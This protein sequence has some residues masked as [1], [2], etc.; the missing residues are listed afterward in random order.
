MIKKGEVIRYDGYLNYLVG[1]IVM[2]YDKSVNDEN[3]WTHKSVRDEKR[4]EEPPIDIGLVI[5]KESGN[6]YWKLVY[7]WKAKT[8]KSVPC[9]HMFWF[10]DSSRGGRALRIPDAENALNEY[11]PYKLLSNYKDQ[12]IDLLE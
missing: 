4:L 7:H 11:A 3:S 6:Q 8:I 9:T 5:G 1:D 12:F 2:I 10:G